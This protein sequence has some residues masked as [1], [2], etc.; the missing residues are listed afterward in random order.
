MT[1]IKSGDFSG[2]SSDYSKNRPDY[3]GSILA[4]LLGLHN[5]G[6]G[7]IEA[8]DIGA[9]TGIWT[10]MIFDAGIKRIVAVEP[11]EDMRNQGAT[12]N[13]GRRIEWRKGS[14]EETGLD[15]GSFDLV[16]MASSFHWADFDLAVREFHRILRPGGRFAAIWNPRLIET[17][18]MLVEIENFLGTLKSDIKRVSSGRSGITATLTEKLNDSQY[19]QD[20][21]YLEGRHDIQ[22]S[23]ERYIGAWRSVNDLQVQLGPKNFTKFI[24]YIEERTMQNP[25]ISATYLT[26]AWSAKKV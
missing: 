1:Q 3:S 12:D 13:Q 8:A 7:E 11:N 20:V 24:S 22:M 23:R 17:N 9:G 18:P 26:R 2:L 6:A 14:A 10:R 16:S 19:F 25:T 4:A 15:S 5:R 21:V